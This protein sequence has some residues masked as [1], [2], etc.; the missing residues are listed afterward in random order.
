MGSGTFLTEGARLL[1]AEGVP[2]FWEHLTGFDI[3]AQVLGIAYVNFYVAILSHLNRRQATTVGDLHV[4]ATDTLDPRNGKY[5]REILPLVPDPD[6]KQFIEQRIRIS[7]EV[8]QTGSFTLVI[9]NPPYRNNS[10]LVLSQVAAVF[11]RLL[12]AAV[13]GA[14]AFQVRNIRDDYAWFFAAADHYVSARGVI[15]FIVS[16]SFAQHLSYRYFREDLLRNYHVRHLIRLGE[17]VFQ[18]VSPRIS[19]AI[20]VLEKRAAALESAEASEAHPYNDLRGLIASSNIADL[21]GELDAR[22]VLMEQVTRGQTTLPA[23]QTLKPTRDSNFS[24]YPSSSTMERIKQSS[25]AIFQK[26]DTRLFQSKMAKDSLR[27]LMSFSRAIL[28]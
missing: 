26:S 21:G 11:P 18:D 22:F 6:Y 10:Q 23:P 12:T 27:H 3:S 1:A 7:A 19:F 8:K 28:G 25:V 13:D 24:L 4:Y 9:G 15:A 14:R 20:V 2:R 5:L 17:S 16:D